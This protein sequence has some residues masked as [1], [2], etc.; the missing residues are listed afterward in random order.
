MKAWYKYIGLGLL[1][2]LVFLVVQFPAN[3]AYSL[4]KPMLDQ[5]KVLLQVYEPQGT[6]WNGRA[7][8]VVYQGR[9]FNRVK[10]QFLP[11]ELLK[12]KLAI[13]VAYKNRDGFAR[14]MISRSLFGDLQLSNIQASL[15]AQEVLALAKI[16]AVK[17]AGQFD[18]NLRNLVLQEKR[19]TEINGRLLW[20]GAES[21]FPQKLKMGDLY[22]DMTTGDDGVIH[23]KLGDGGGPLELSGKLDVGPDGKYDL[24]LEMASRQGRNSVL[25]RSLGF[26][27]RYN[28]KGK[29]EFKRSGNISEFGFLVKK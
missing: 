24:A 9:S 2:Y 3:Q 15:S 18:L 20:T 11:V 19:V 4:V 14:A 17:L 28:N 8:R 27:G 16:P 22:A 7:S 21:Q 12:G 23:V 10:W 25:G 5:Q 1:L 26:I 13:F 6:I 29:A